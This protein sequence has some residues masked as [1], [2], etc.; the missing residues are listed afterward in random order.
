MFEQQ[1]R[2]LAQ[3]PVP[4]AERGVRPP[5]EQ[6]HAA[7]GAAEA[8]DAGAGPPEEGHEADLP[9]AGRRHPP[10]L[11]VHLAA[12]LAGQQLPLPPPHPPLPAPHGQHDYDL[13]NLLPSK[14]DTDEDVFQFGYDPD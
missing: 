6:H 11:A 8:G 4:D 13:N 12:V 3:L 2:L 9:G 1:Q 5:A 7:E 10:P 14:M